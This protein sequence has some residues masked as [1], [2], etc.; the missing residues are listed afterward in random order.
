MEKKQFPRRQVLGG[1]AGLAAAATVGACG[2]KSN[3]TNSSSTSGTINVW[4]GVPAE[5]GPNDLVAL[6]EKNF[7][8]AKVNYERFVNDPQGNV[9]LD[10][11]LQGGAPIDVYFSYAPATFKQRAS[12]GLALDIT[13]RIKSEPKFKSLASTENPQAQWIDGK[14]FA[15][16]TLR[17]PTTVLVNEQILEASGESIP[18]NWNLD[19]FRRIAKAMSKD[20]QYGVFN[21]PDLA[22]IQLGRN[23]WYK[24]DGK[25]SNFDHPA[26]RESMQLRLDMQKEKS[27]FPWSEVLA[28]KLEIY[29]QSVYLTGKFGLWVT[30]TFNLRYISDLKEYPHDFKT[31]CMPMPEIPGSENWN[32][33]SLGNHIMISSKSKNQDLAWEF[34]KFY[35]TDGAQP[36][37]RSGRIPL[38]P[39]LDEQTVVNELLGPDRDKIYNVDSFKKVLFNKETKIPVDSILTG[40]VGITK[41]I[42]THRDQLFL[43]EINID[44]WAERLKKDADAAIAADK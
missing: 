21:A 38:I 40:A 34:V 37:V 12:A 8:N 28:Q 32:T 41:A 3:S 2:E 31:R 10:T 13:D 42:Q 44:Q 33:G 25:E 4:G 11:A 19:D 9:K 5:S 29:Q 6:F 14:L 26:F 30:D 23:F 15:V 7:P 16:P 27:A 17:Q 20:K 39:G 43:G 36:M 24:N 18:D 22:R 1:I 35:L